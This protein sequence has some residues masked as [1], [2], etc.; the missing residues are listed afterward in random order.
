MGSQ[1]ELLDNHKCGSEMQDYSPDVIP[2]DSVGNTGPGYN[3][4]GRSVEDLRYA[5][6]EAAK[7]VETR[8]LAKENT[9]NTSFSSNGDRPSIQS[10]EV[11]YSE[12][13]F[14]GGSLG[15]PPNSTL[16]GPSAPQNCPQPQQQQ[17]R[18]GT[19]YALI[20][21][22]T[23]K[24]HQQNASN[25]AHQQQNKQATILPRPRRPEEVM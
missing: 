13:V 25:L 8:Q 6:I 3:A 4:Y 15:G 14:S 19:E 10:P 17:H 24:Q 2:K 23:S 22:Q 1:L 18:G 7:A 12:L 9:F 20:M 21:P 11:S 5:T 16:G